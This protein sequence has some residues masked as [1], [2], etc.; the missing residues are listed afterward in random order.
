MPTATDKTVSIEEAIEHAKRA[1]ALGKYEQAVEDYATALELMTMKYGE[2]APETADLY[3]AYGKSL[4]ENA[5]AQS[6]VLGKEQTEDAG[7]GELKASGKFLS[8][9][10]DTEDNDELLPEGKEDVAVDL[11]AEAEKAV[12][13]EDEREAEEEEAEPEDDFNAAWEV[14]DLARAIYEREQDD[15]AI[16][17]KLADTFIALG[18][19]SLETEKFDQAITDYTEALKLKAELLPQSSRQIAEAHYKM[20]IVLDLTSGRLSDAITHAERALES[21]EA[22]LAELRDALSGQGVVQIEL[23]EKADAKGKGKATGPRILGD[24]AI[25]K[26]NKTQMEA[27]VKELQDLREDLALKVEELKTAPD[28]QYESAPAMVAKAL[29]KELNGIASAMKSVTPQTVTDLTSIVKKKK[30]NPDAGP[31][32]GDKRKAE[33]EPIPSLPSEKKAR[34]EEVPEP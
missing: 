20:S 27:E 17:L 16:K 21:V 31:D 19:V 14:L 28:E 25:Q 34:V 1:F 7:L 10:G 9:S 3:F 15:D 18:D 32:A 33:E 29:D 11:F 22:R 30:K 23:D 26:M 8:F 24:D 12:A 6:S 13:E 5:I 2:K 4:L